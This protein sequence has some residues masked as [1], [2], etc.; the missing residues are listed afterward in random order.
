[1]QRPIY[2]PNEKIETSLYTSGKE[3]MTIDN[4]EY[5][6]LYHQYPNNA[7]YSEAVFSD[8]SIELVQ[9]APPIESENDSM[10]FKMTGTRFNNY[11]QP[12]YYYP[13]VS[14][15]DYNSAN[16]IRY[17]I[18]QKNN[19]LN[20]IE[21]DSNQYLKINNENKPGIDSGIYYKESINWSISGP[22]DD[23]RK[24]NARVILFTSINGLDTYLTDLTEFYK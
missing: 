4:Q 19:L 12:K 3:W 2:T 9:Y 20:I 23:V 21:I 10:Y 8:H 7:V 11:V 16:F 24:A 14:N 22:I 1:M 18:Q 13:E 6:G 5:I 15:S 17:F